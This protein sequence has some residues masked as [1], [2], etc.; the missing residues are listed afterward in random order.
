VVDQPRFS[1]RKVAARRCAR[2]IKPTSEASGKSIFATLSANNERW[3]AG[4]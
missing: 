1:P 2:A 3:N 4:I